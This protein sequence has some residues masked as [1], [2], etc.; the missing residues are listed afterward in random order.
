MEPLP[1][2]WMELLL[3]HALSVGANAVDISLHPTGKHVVA[4][5]ENGTVAFCGI[6]ESGLN[7]IYTFQATLL[8][9][10]MPVVPCTPMDS[11]VPLEPRRVPSTCGILKI[12]SLPIPTRYGVHVL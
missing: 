7:S 10:S 8:V 6:A 12:K 11:F 1:N 5:V 2:M 9:P 3:V 4:I